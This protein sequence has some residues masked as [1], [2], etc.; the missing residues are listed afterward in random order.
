MEYHG[1][2]CLDTVIHM[3]CWRTREK[4]KK[5]DPF[6]MCFLTLRKSSN[7]FN[8]FHDNLTL[9]KSTEKCWLER[10][11]NSHLR[12]TG[13]PLCLLNDRVHRDWRRVFIQLKCTRYSRDDLTL[14]HER[15][16]SVSILFQNHPKSLY[17]VFISRTE[18]NIFKYGIVFS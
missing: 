18:F 6:L 10:N 2:H 4:R 8:V 3:E 15:M 12:D 17:H 13:P 5:H 7:I 14:I 16:C 11:L 9:P 1:Y